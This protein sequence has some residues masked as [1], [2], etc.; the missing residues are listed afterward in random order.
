MLLTISK[1]LD[2]SASRRLSAPGWSD[3]AN[4]AAFGADADARHG[5]GRNY[6]AVFV[7]AGAVDPATGMVINVAHAKRP[8]NE[9][10]T[11]RYDHHFLNV[12]TPPF[13]TV[14][15]TPE[16]IASQLLADAAPL[17][18]GGPAELAV[19]HVRES[20]HRA[21]TAYA[22]GRVEGHHRVE[23]SAARVTRSPHLTDAENADLFGIAASPHG[24]GHHYRLRVTLAGPRH[25]DTGLAAPPQDVRAALDDLVAQLD[26]RHLNIE[27]PWLADAPMTT[28]SLARTLHAR[29][30]ARLPV[31]R[32]RLYERDDF[33]CEHHAGGATFMARQRLLHAAHRLHSARLDAQANRDIYG[34]CNN[35]TGHGHTYRVEATIG[36]EYDAR[37]G[38]LAP[39]PWLGDGIDEA[40]APWQDR[41]LDLETGDFTDRPSTSENIIAALWPR[42]DARL[43]GRLHRLRL[44]ETPNNRFALRR[45]KD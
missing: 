9:L 27:V 3:D 32:V 23:W 39:F 11:A 25:D 19:V 8:L 16:N 37:T 21:A 2:F 35:P 24:H 36:G 17:F 29:L 1:R 31:Q 28:E 22:D 6:M 14:A 12:D 5:T 41:H 10:L 44:W 34:R 20:D 33:F 26:H 18:A 38:A 13:D 43:D 45:G 40:L 4:R 30:A 7:F 15:P 42:L